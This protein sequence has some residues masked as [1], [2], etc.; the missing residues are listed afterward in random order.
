[1]TI[2][3]IPNA[4]CYF[5]ALSVFLSLSTYMEAASFL[6]AEAAETANLDP[7]ELDPAIIEDANATKFERKDFEGNDESFTHVVLRE[8][9]GELRPIGAAA[10]YSRSIPLSEGRQLKA[11]EIELV[12]TSDSNLHSV[13]LAL[14][15]NV[16]NED[17]DVKD[18][19]GPGGAEMALIAMEIS[20]A[21]PPG[22][23]C[24]YELK[25]RGISVP[26]YDERDMLAH[27]MAGESVNHSFKKM[28][29]V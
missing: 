17:P 12:A 19:D 25:R 2:E 18:I 1:M 3:Y 29:P 9:D 26:T 10:V 16:I 6:P 11:A 15:H 13:Y 5:Y 27:L 23:Y 14:V 20:R 4:H 21:L 22:W 28:R 7:A 24:E 8:H